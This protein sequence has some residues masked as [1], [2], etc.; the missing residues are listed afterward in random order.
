MKKLYILLFSL[1]A[2]I[3]PTTDQTSAL[4]DDYV[5]IV[6]LENPQTTVSKSNVSKLLLKR[7]SRWDDDTPALPIDLDSRSPVRESFS[8]DVHGRSV[9]SIKSY[10]QRQI[11]SGK[12][13][14]HIDHGTVN[15][16][17]CRVQISGM[18]RT[19]AAE[20]DRQPGG[21]VPTDDPHGS[22]VVHDILGLQPRAAQRL[23]GILDRRRRPALQSFHETL[24]PFHT[25][26]GRQPR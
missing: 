4:A 3:L 11:F 6:N 20:I 5:V 26:L 1:V 9:A 16:R 7:T 25:L 14:Q 13:S 8:R 18:H 10:W 23:K 19:R 15:N 22:A 2:L 17:R 24:N 21:F 12:Q